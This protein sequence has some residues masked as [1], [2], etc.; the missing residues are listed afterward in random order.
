M[1]VCVC[2]VAVVEA[3]ISKHSMVGG[4]STAREQCYFLSLVY[5]LQ[6][7]RKGFPTNKSES[8]HDISEECKGLPNPEGGSLFAGQPRS[9]Y[10]LAQFIAIHHI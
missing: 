3:V 4:F 10:S 6:P 1:F 2:F 8:L 5:R 7:Q 9:I